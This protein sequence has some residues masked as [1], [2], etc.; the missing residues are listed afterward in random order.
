M[1]SS[2]IPKE[3]II[4]DLLYSPTQGPPGWHPKLL[5]VVVLSNPVLEDTTETVSGLVVVIASDLFKF[6][7]IDAQRCSN[8]SPSG[9]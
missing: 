5:G 3:L 2:Y 1:L 7:P 4:R 9:R 8:V 6:V